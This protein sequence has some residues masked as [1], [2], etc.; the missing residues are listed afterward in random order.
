[1]PR[2]FESLYPALIHVIKL[3]GRLLFI[4]NFIPCFRIIQCLGCPHNCGDGHRGPPANF[5][6]TQCQCLLN[7]LK[8]YDKRQFSNY[9]R[10]FMK[11]NSLNC[12]ISFIHSYVGFCT[13]PLSIFSPMCTCELVK[14]HCYIPTLQQR[15]CNG[16]LVLN[17]CVLS[18]GNKRKSLDT[19]SQLSVSPSGYG[20]SVCSKGNEYHVISVIFRSLITRV[21]LSYKELKHPENSVSNLP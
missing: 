1:M 3:Y 12:I 9:L 11:N 18:T 14:I 15:L 4:F 13:E 16:R 8:Q 17:Y 19:I 2:V 20:P 5:V 10:H 6:R 7:R 21:V